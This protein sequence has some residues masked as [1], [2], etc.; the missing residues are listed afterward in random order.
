M[1]TEEIISSINETR[2]P[3]TELERL[4][5][6][7]GIYAFTLTEGAELGKFGSAGRV[8]F[9]GLAEKSLASRDTKSHLKTGQTGGSSLRRSL[10]AV[11]KQELSLTALPRDKNGKKPR[12]DKYKFNPEGER[13]LTN[14]MIENLELGYW[15][16]LEEPFSTDE[17][18]KE[19]E[20][21]IKTLKPTLDLDRRT[22]RFNPLAGE[23]DALR[24]VCRAAVRNTSEI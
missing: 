1:R 7:Q 5:T 8:I 9:V 12:P 22:K 17:L 24:E 11:L 15:E 4:P 20:Q 16:N 6:K 2:K 14:W 13:K 3:I 18:R 21:V 10:G 19:E 23:L